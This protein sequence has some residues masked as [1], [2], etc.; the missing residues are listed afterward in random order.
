MLDKLLNAVRNYRQPYNSVDPHRVVLMN[1][2]IGRKSIKNAESDPRDLFEPRNR[3]VKIKSE[4][5]AKAGCFD[6]E[7][8]KKRFEYALLREHTYNIG[9]RRSDIVSHYSHKLAAE[10]S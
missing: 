4:C 3:F 5:Y 1:D 9:K 7:D 10:R 6:K 8:S 2:R